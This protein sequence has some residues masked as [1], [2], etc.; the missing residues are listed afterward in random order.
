MHMPR[1]L[2][3]LVAGSQT[4]VALQTMQAPA[5][6]VAQ[7][8][9]SAHQL[10]MQSPPVVHVDPSMPSP[11]GRIPPVPPAPATPAPRS[12]RAPSGPSTGTAG[13]RA[14]HERYGA[15]VIDTSST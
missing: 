6:S 5:H 11:V 3:P 4:P 13:V 7:Q 2:L 8:T 9:L 10:L 1:G 14:C 12:A 15:R